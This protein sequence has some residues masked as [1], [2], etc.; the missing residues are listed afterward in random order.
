MTEFEDVLADMLECA[1]IEAATSTDEALIGDLDNWKPIG[2][3]NA[4]DPAKVTVANFR[5]SRR[6]RAEQL[7]EYR[8]QHGLDTPQ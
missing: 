2:I 7:A 8:R 3:L 5:G 6:S 1:G 4:I